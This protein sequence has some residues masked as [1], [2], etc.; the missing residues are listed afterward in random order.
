MYQDGHIITNDEHIN[1]ANW[2][3]ANGGKF[4]SESNEDGTLTIREIVV[5]EPTVEEQNEIIKKT[6]ANLYAELID[7][8]H[9]EKQRK[10]VIGKWTDADEEQYVSAVKRLTEKIQTE[11]PY[12]E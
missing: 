2:N 6:R 8:L 12:L 7:K 4:H 1:F 11:N 5:V 3:N 9:A 10:V